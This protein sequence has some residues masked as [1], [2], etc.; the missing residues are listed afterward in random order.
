MR[1]NQCGKEFIP[2]NGMNRYCSIECRN[3]HSGRKLYKQGTECECVTCGKTFKRLYGSE[4]YCS[5]E[6]RATGTKERKRVIHKENVCVVCGKS[7]MPSKQSQKTCS[8]ECR[9]AYKQQKDSER[10]SKGCSAEERTNHRREVARRNLEKARE[11]L[12]TI[13]KPKQLKEKKWY[14]GNCVVCG[15]PFKT[16]HQNQKTCSKECGKRLKYARKHHRIKKEQIVDKDITLEALYRRDSGVCY[17]CGG[18]CDWEDRDTLNNIVGDNYPSIDHIIPVAR[19]GLHA[20]NNVRL[21]HFKCNVAKSDSMISEAESLIPENAYEFKRY[22]PPRMKQVS[23]YTKD[24][25]WIATFK[26]TAEAERMTGVKS[27]G[28]Q[29]CA[30]NECKTYGGFMWKYSP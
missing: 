22:V 1:C 16:L 24:G 30:R 10:R 4:K 27:K 26:S 28:I 17:L 11:K 13:R 7:F 8:V 25:Q 15:K 6:C 14:T 3:K 2:T 18:I 23:Q 9:T 19:G 5:V 21:A 12:N 29:N 20:W